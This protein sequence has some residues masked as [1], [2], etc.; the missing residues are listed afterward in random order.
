MAFILMYV[1]FVV[2]LFLLYMWVVVL[3]RKQSWG[4]HIGNTPVCPYV[5]PS[6]CACVC[7]SVCTWVCTSVC[8][9]VCTFV[10]KESLA[11]GP[12]PM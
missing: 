10:L 6:V 7:P 8:T 3:P 5:C 1:L 12:V 9:W 2:V 4:G 11:Y